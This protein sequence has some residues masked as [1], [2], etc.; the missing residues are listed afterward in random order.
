MGRFTQA[1]LG[2]W[3]A[4]SMTMAQS[5]VAPSQAVNSYTSKSQPSST[6]SHSGSGG[7]TS[8]NA[9]STKSTFDADTSSTETHIDTGSYT[10]DQGES[11][12][13]TDYLTQHKLPLVGA[14]VLKGADGKRAIVLYGFV[15][16]D[17]GKSDAA[18]KAQRYLADQ[19]VLVDNRIKVRPEL[20]AST[21]GT[22]A[23]SG[24]SS[25]PS[26][27]DNSG[28]PGVRSYVQ[29][30]NND[31]AIRQYQQSQNSA[32][33]MSTVVPL[34]ALLGVLGMGMAAG[35]SGFA[36]GPGSIGPPSLSPFGSM[37]YNPYP[38]YASPYGS[39]PYGASP[40]GGSPYGSPPSSPYYP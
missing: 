35:G 5:C 6:T 40:Y 26:Q 34:I 27:P 8:T 3:F 15:G 39:P 23:A 36:I 11:R 10:A 22:S 17:F 1:V 31:E 13:L 12:A 24:S 16:S 33:T 19:S 21:G 25:S 9:G 28:Y 37:P 2:G 29:Q 14:Q 7:L 18:V 20:L 4:V 30:Q 38:G 32:A